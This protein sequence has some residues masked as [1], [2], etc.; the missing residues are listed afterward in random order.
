M[1]KVIVSPAAKKRE[2]L[3]FS[4]HHIKPTNG[5]GKK[6]STVTTTLG[7]EEEEDDVEVHARL[8]CEDLS[9]VHSLARPNLRRQLPIKGSPRMS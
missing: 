4:S 9:N 7:L 6:G 2:Q 8:D 1:G 3:K 5:G